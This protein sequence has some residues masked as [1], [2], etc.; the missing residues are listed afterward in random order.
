MTRLLNGC[1]GLAVGLIVA[2]ASAAAQ[3]SET[4]SFESRQKGRPVQITATVY[5]PAAGGRVPALVLHHGSG[6]VTEGL[7]G[8]AQRYAGMGV[9]GV[10]ID[11]FQGRGVRSTVQDQSAVTR[12]D[13]NLDALSVLK[14]LG[15]NPRIDAARIGIAGFSK[16]GG[17]ALMASQVQ[18]RTAAGVP[19]TLKYAFHVAFYPS[20]AVQPYRPITTGAP[21]LM[22]LGGADTYAG[23]EPCE[24][25]GAAL[26]DGG[27]NIVVRVFPGAP[28]GY[29]SGQAGSDPRGENN[30]Q[31][32]F[33]QQAS[34]AW[35]ERRTGVMVAGADGRWMPDAVTKAFAGCRTLGVSWG[36]DPDARRLAHTELQSYVQRF[37]LQ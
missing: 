36:P 9:A 30:S 28:H 31:C 19:P 10:V 29:D 18:E 6:G 11:S 15:T 14:A 2:S 25:Y 8:M 16:G 26:R 33:Q 21:I 17:A 35:V 34:G 23:T 1:W 24:T 13:F 5:W 12:E 4:I 22:L 27:A 7:K 3:Q 32:V 20:C 37:L